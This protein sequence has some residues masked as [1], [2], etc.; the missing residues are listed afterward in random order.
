MSVKW[1]FG[2]RYPTKS[3]YV[4]LNMV[5][6]FENVEGQVT[7]RGSFVLVMLEKS[8]T[9]VRKKSGIGSALKTLW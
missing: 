2:I 9:K 1:V 6:S 4:T 3:N 7:T 5:D 8:S